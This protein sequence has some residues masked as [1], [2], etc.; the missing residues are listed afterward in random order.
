MIFFMF[1]LIRKISEY[2]GTDITLGVFC[3]IQGAEAA[4]QKYRDK[5]LTNPE[6]DPWH[7][8]AHVDEHLSPVHLV[9]EE[10]E[11][12]QVASGSV[13]LVSKY[14]EAFGQVDREIIQVYE[15][16]RDAKERCNELDIEHDD[17][18]H[19][20]LIQELIIG[21]IASDAPGHQPEI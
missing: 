7:E 10:L 8:Q 3:E 17:F 16:P 21:E 11:G 4:A 18:P 9:V 2:T 1:L 13:Y 14:T 6:L 12:E 15:N 5:Y 19:Y 20:S